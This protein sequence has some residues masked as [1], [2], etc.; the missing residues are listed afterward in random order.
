[1]ASK[2]FYFANFYYHNQRQIK[3]LRAC[4]EKQDVRVWIKFR[5]NDLRVLKN[6]FC[7]FNIVQSKPIFNVNF[8][9]DWFWTVDLWCQ[10]RPLHLLSHNLFPIIPLFDQYELLC[11]AKWQN[12]VSKNFW[13]STERYF[14]MQFKNGQVTRWVVMTGQNLSKEGCLQ[15]DQQK[16][17]KCL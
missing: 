15:C 7:L 14:K 11:I 1:M 8:A 10:K 4:V 12:N 16:V 17:A 13:C 9:D 5:E 6:Y 2:S 3:Y